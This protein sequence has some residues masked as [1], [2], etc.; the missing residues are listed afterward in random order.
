[1]VDR[2]AGLTNR[3]IASERSVSRRTAEE[4]DVARILRNYRDSERR[5]Q[6]AAWVTLRPFA[7][8]VA[9]SLAVPAEGRYGASHFLLDLSK[10][11]SI[12][13]TPSG[14]PAGA[15]LRAALYSAHVCLNNCH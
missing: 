8:L 13:T 15:E 1:M 11:W 14:C 4:A 9:G 7:L 12:V 5:T 3:E 10:K 6:L 2:V